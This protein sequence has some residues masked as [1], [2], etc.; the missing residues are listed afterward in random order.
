M[1]LP[2]HDGFA[3]SLLIRQ[4]RTTMLNYERAMKLHSIIRL[5]LIIVVSMP[6]GWCCFVRAADCCSTPKTTSVAQKS[7]S[8][9]CCKRIAP[10]TCEPNFSEAQRESSPRSCQCRCRCEIGIPSSR[11]NVVLDILDSGWI[12]TC[13]I[14]H[15]S[16][17]IPTT[18]SICYRERVPLQILHCS[19]QC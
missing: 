16:Y 14:E 10:D 11:P 13:Q 17:S 7:P 15:F 12:E 18:A 9:D 3:V 6:Q 5:I 19:W 8:C 4:A 1:P 2:L